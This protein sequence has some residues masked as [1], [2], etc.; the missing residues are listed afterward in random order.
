VICGD[1]VREGPEQCDDGNTTNLD[2]CDSSCRFEQLQRST[3]L[4][5]LGSTDSFCTANALGSQAFTAAGLG[6]IQSAID[7]DVNLG[8]TNVIF[9]FMTSNGSGN[10]LSGTSGPV[11]IGSLSGTPEMPDAGPYNGNNDVDWWYATDPTMVDTSRNPLT[12][13]TGTYTS[14][15]LSVT[16]GRLTLKMQIAGSPAKLDIWNVQIEASIGSTSTPKTS[17]GGP[18]GHLASENLDPALTSFQ[19]AGVGASGP[20]AELCGNT[21]AASLAAVSVPPIIATGG[22]VPCDEGYKTGT[23]TLLDVIIHGCSVGGTGVFNAT[24]PDP[25]LVD[26]TVPLPPGTKAPYTLSASVASTFVVDTCMDGST[27]AKPVP[28]AT[29]L[30]ALAYTSAFQYQTDRVI[31]K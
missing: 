22:M 6:Q 3:S 10:D 23:N 29:C 18:P 4:K 19:T 14:K 27:P 1:G 9:K 13:V 28:I 7:S 31:L 2:G 15:K 30:K 26:P 24:Q 5:F 21:T 20:T 8:R 17:T 12:T 25:G 16:S 11:V